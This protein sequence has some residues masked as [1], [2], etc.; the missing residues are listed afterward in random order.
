MTSAD[1]KRF[2]FVKFDK[3]IAATEQIDSVIDKEDLHIPLCKYISIYKH[4]S[5]YHSYI[6]KIHHNFK[7]IEINAPTLEQ[8]YQQF[9]LPFLQKLHMA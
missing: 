2:H 5:S 8:F 4:L 7:Q 9:F 6:F 3:K 1:Y